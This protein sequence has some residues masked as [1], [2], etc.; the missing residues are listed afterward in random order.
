MYSYTLKIYDNRT[1][2]L[3]VLYHCYNHCSYTLIFLN[4][5]TPKTIN[6]LFGRNGKLILGVPI[7]MHIKVLQF[8]DDKD[9]NYVQLIS[10][11][12]IFLYNV[13]SEKKMPAPKV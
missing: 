10:V 7:L 5:G 4:I 9:I 3:G 8:F 13:C 12:K 1:K 2:S 11:H 6:F